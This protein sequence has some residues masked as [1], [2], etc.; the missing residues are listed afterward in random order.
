MKRIGALALYLTQDLFHSFAGI[1][2]LAAALAFGLIAFEYGMDQAQ[3]ITVGAVGT[4]V[5]GLL[6]TIL[7][8]GRADRASSYLVLGRLHRRAELLVS[9][10]LSGLC[11]T[12]VLAVLITAANLMAGRLTLDL[13]S[14]LWILPT[15]LAFWFFVLCLSLLLTT[16]TSRASSHLV[17]Y[18]LLVAVLVANDR[19]AWLTDHRLSW[20]VRGVTKALWPFT[21]LLSSAS[22]GDHA[23]TYWVAFAL[24]VICGLVAFGL[25]A[26]LFEDKDLLWAG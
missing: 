23:G 7:L 5:I 18:L 4:G 9:I 6:C 26:T 13:P 14:A 10:V 16:L 1:I 17:G 19:R 15:W 11:L 2:P 21:S 25:A 22:A 24:T 20:L 12:T 8:A 3:F